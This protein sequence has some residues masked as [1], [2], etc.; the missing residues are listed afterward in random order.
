MYPSYEVTS[1]ILRDDLKVVPDVESG[2]ALRYGHRRIWTTDVYFIGNRNASEFKGNVGFRTTIGYPE[3][4]NPLT[5]EHRPLP[6]FTRKGHQTFIPLN[7]QGNESGFIVFSANRHKANVK[8]NFPELTPVKT[9]SGTWNV[10]FAASYPAPNPTILS[11]LTDLSKNVNEGIKFFSGK[12]T[13]T[14]LFNA[15]TLVERRAVLSLG[16]VKNMATVRLNGRDL[17]TAWCS[18]WQIEIPKGALKAKDNQLEITVA[19]L[20]TNRLIG[21]AGK[22]ESQRM[23]KVSWSPLTAQSQLQPSGLIGPVKILQ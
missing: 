22:P 5:G 6:V 17:G 7:L 1:K 12:A 10:S 3:W 13:Y 4:W 21:D 11:D 2:D 18:P 14:K 15:D 19:N 23:T 16:E 9:L 8:V 20:W